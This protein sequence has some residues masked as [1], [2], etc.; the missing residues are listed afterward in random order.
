MAK[1]VTRTR[2]R[3]SDHRNNIEKGDFPHPSPWSSG[4]KRIQNL[5]LI[6]SRM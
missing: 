4:L 1:D 3:G 2:M 6:D 5:I